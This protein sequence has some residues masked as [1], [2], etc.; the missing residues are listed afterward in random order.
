M[1]YIVQ[2]PL[3]AR[4]FELYYDL[5][6][7]VLRAPWN[8]ARGS[9][10]DASENTS[11]HAMILEG[12]LCIACGRL[13]KTETEG[14]GQIRFMAVDPQYQGKSLGKRIVNYLEARAKDEQLREIILQSRENAV[15]FYKALGYEIVEPTFKLFGEIQ[16]YLMRKQLN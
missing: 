13:Q 2:S 6:Y 14:V 5:R 11:T 15:E 9:E 7:R 3:N 1:N 4:E 10:Q 12:D 16:H 8:Q